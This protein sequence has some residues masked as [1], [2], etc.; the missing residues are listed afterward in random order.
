MHKLKK[1][2]MYFIAVVLAGFSYEASAQESGLP[3]HLSTYKGGNNYGKKNIDWGYHRDGG[4]N[5]WK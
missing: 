5:L 1:R 4:D 3:K 2:L